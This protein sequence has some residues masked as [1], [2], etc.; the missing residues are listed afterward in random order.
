VYFYLLKVGA[1]ETSSPNGQAG[2][3][4]IQTKKM[5]YLK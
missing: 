2:Q 4:I 1:P 5:I 3:E